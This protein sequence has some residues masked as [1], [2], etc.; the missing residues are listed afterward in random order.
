MKE[1]TRNYWNIFKAMIPAISL[2]VFGWVSIALSGPSQTFELD[3][4]IDPDT[5]SGCHSEK[6]E[7]WSNSMHNLSHKDPVYT[8]V[9]LFLL[10]GLTDQ[11]EIDEAESCVKCHT[12]VGVITGFPEK[13]S[14]DLSK[15]PEI[16]TRGIQCDYCHSAVNLE[17]MYNNGLVLEP[18]YGEDD[19]G[20]KRGPFEDAEPDFHEAAY[21]PL[22]D[23]AEFCGT[24]HDVKHVTF[25][26]D[27]ETTYTEW[28]NSPYNSDDPEK[29]ITCQGCHMYQRPGVPAT[30]STDRPENPG[31]SADY[32]RERPHTY[33]H[34]F[35]GG[36]SGVPASFGDSEKPDMAKERLQHAAKLDLDL[37]NLDK[38]ELGVTV[39]NTGAGHSL[40]TGLADMR[41]MWLEI[42]ILDKNGNR[43]FESGILDEKKELPDNALIYRTVFGDGKGN[44]VLNLSKAREVLHDNRIPARGQAT[45]VIPLDQV[46][47]KESEIQVRLL[48]RSMPQKVLNLL[49]GEPLGPLPVVEMA[50]V[51]HVL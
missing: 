2:T 19:P 14:D 11:G 21:S 50:R 23:S 9:A 44:L 36:N 48:Y 51:T 13:L 25:G 27:L 40:P 45:E 24:C 15:T 34:Y 20:T 17:K 1:Q 30:G 38:K 26:T 7:Q 37:S 33:T 41:Q 4:F 18:G 6:F 47:E 28:K 43:V 8:R 16:A 3:R 49:P 32:S 42:I 46:L 29:R 35:V 5:C 31:S 39:S 10:Q 22:H 12:P